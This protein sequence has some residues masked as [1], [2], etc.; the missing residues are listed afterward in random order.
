MKANLLRIPSQ[1]DDIH[2]ESI[3]GNAIDSAQLQKQKVFLE[4]LQFEEI[5]LAEREECVQKIEADVL[6][7]NKIMNDL[8]SL[9]SE[10]GNHMGELFLI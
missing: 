2:R 4:N 7:V 5:L 9:V 10:Q 1:T 3:N 8:A 6:D